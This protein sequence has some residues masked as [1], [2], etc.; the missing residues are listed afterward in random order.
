MISV[1]LKNKKNKQTKKQEFVTSGKKFK[2]RNKKESFY[3][4]VK[5]TCFKKRRQSFLP[6][7]DKR[8]SAIMT[9]VLNA[10]VNSLCWNIIMTSKKTS[11][12]YAP[13]GRIF[14][15]NQ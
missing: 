8:W 10:I 3:F 9:A 7:P 6:S 5:I 15:R 2:R 1:I 4:L 12:E 14:V 13:S 11:Y